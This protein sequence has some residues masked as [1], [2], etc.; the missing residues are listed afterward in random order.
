MRTEYL[1]L[2]GSA[3]D[4]AKVAHAAKLLQAGALVAFP[5]E[6]VYGLGADP[7]NPDAIA[8]LTAVKG[9]K[10]NKPYSL[11]VPSLRQAE[12]L[13]GGFPRIAQ[14]LARVFWP[15]PLTLVVPR[16]DG[17]TIGLRLPDHPVARSL[18]AH[19][20][21]ALATP[22]ANRSGTVEPVTAA[23]VREALDGQVALILD[24]GPARQGRPSAVVRVEN[25]LLQIQREGSIPNAELLET[26]SP[27]V[28]FV[29]RGNTCR[30]PMAAGFCRQGVAE[31]HGL[32]PVATAHA[33]GAGGGILPYRVLSAGT[34]AAA[35]RGAD[36]LAVV[37]MREAGVDISDHRT[38]NL[39]PAWV[40]NADW[41][42]TM[43]HGQRE[44]ILALMPTA[45]N[46]VQLLSSRHEDIPD[47]ATGS[48]ELYRRVRDKIASCLRDVVKLV[49][50]SGA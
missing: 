11:L 14:K 31:M 23:Q 15:G 50:R 18:L 26:A 2:D 34:N 3:T 25:E 13:A 12:A 28:L 1:T 9:R 48:L 27:T 41:I 16:R 47:P 7:R 6:T 46:R 4:A 36:K 10:D 21:F 5:T 22:S 49:G 43:T 32:G 38:R 37:A 8:R 33:G 24:G 45:A 30:S 40:D 19:C 35:N 42:F 39:T 29:C 44:S 17:G 20:G